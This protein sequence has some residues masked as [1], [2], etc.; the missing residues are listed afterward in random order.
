M[1]AKPKHETL[2]RLLE[3]LKALPTH[4]WAT[5][6]EL[7]ELLSARGFDVDLRSVQRDLKELQQSFALDHNDKGKPHGWR[8]SEQAAGSVTGLSTPEALMLVLAEQ[9]LQNALPATMLE[10]FQT[11]FER[12]H[13]RLD[14]LNTRSGAAR[15]P[16]KV[17]SISP[18]L[19][20][21]P[22]STEPSV[23]R[24][25][26]EA[27]LDG[28]MLDLDYAPGAKGRT[29]RYTLHPLGLILRGGVTYLAAV[30][31]EGDDPRLYALHRIR[32]A[33]TSV[34]PVL[35]QSDQMFSEAVA[36]GLGQFG[37]R[38][39]PSGQVAIDL[40]CDAGLAA[41]MEESP[42][43]SDQCLSDL[44]GGRRRVRA[45]LPNS[46]ELRWWLM[47]RAAEVEVLGPPALRDEIAKLLSAAVAQY[48]T[49][50]QA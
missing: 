40:A 22:P 27:L 33:E 15:W 2:N 38:S 43:S 42:L 50:R 31:D 14:R 18:G 35:P 25:V 45:T 7:R 12:A 9:H 32:Q 5:A 28:R 20:G 48:A 39:G 34:H 46:W 37:V 16:A 6:V 36:A 26:A 17:R 10:G 49:K 24:V 3:L 21:K 11:L 8:W 1:P 19:A 13:Q 23:Q 44:E 47:G 29:R 30:R 41:L 4:R